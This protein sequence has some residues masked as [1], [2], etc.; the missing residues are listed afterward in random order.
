MLRQSRATALFVRSTTNV[1]RALLANTDVQF[2]ATATSG[3]DHIDHVWCA[4]NKITV[5]DAAGSNANAVAEWVMIVLAELK[6]FRTDITVGIV[7]YGHVGSRVERMCRT[8]GLNTLVN[9]PPRQRAG[10]PVPHSVELDELLARCSVVSLHVPMIRTGPDCTMD[11]ISARELALLPQHAMMINTARGGI[12]NESDALQWM[13]HGFRYVAADTFANEPDINTAFSKACTIATPHIAGHTLNAFVDASRMIGEAW[14]AWKQVPADHIRKACR[15]V[16]PK[17]KPLVA[18][19][20]E[21]VQPIRARFNRRFS[22][23][24][25][26]MQFAVSDAQPQD[27]ANNFMEIRRT[28]ILRKETYLL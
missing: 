10:L 3:T 25:L 24:C 15:P 2:V 8:L 7:G 27:V 9:D 5:V 28:H 16:Y 19:D 14:C 13:E 22:D 21:L 6:A 20:N 1:D 17:P 26:K 11:L 23:V 4:N 18:G 12:L